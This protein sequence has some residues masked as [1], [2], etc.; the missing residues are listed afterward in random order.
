MLELFETPSEDIIALIIDVSML[1]L[2]LSIIG[3]IIRIISG[4]PSK[5]GIKNSRIIILK[6]SLLFLIFVWPFTYYSL[7]YLYNPNF[8]NSD[9][10][11]SNLLIIQ[12]C[13]VYYSMFVASKAIVNL[14][15]EK[16]KGKNKKTF[17]RKQVLIMLLALIGPVIIKLLSIICFCHIS[18][19][20]KY[21]SYEFVALII[22]SIYLFAL[23]FYVI[24]N[25]IFKIAISIALII[26]IIITTIAFLKVKDD[27]S[28]EYYSYGGSCSICNSCLQNV[29]Y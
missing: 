25:K 4:K 13:L 27:I 24:S 21:N 10:V 19:F 14:I 28:K 29:E 1:V 3:D 2:L 12:E 22:M 26:T 11:A 8:N 7:I 15:I 17:A 18:L 20:D 23:T 5:S 16:P 9:N 6:L